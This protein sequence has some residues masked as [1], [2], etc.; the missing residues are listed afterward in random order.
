MD[1]NISKRTFGNKMFWIKY[2]DNFKRKYIWLKKPKFEKFQEKKLRYA[3]EKT[4][5]L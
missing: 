1:M 4:Y 3:L 5:E 2:N